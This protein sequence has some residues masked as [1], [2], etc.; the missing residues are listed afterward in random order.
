[1]VASLIKA[2]NILPYMKC[3]E[4]APAT[5]DELSSFHS[6][7]Y[8]EYLS[9]LSGDVD[10]CESDLEYGLGKIYLHYSYFSLTFNR[11]VKCGVVKTTFPEK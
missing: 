3:V 1:M 10:D 2:Y 9:S 5:E 4:S 7:S 6:S 8:I 11:G